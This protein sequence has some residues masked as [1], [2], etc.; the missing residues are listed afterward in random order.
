MKPLE[1][2]SDSKLKYIFYHLDFFIDFNPLVQYISYGSNN[3]NEIT[4]IYIP[5]QD[6]VPNT[7]FRIQ[8]LPV[9]FTCSE[10]DA[11][12]HPEKKA[13]VFHHDILK[14]IFYLLSGYQ[15]YQTKSLDTLGRF[16]Y[17]SSVQYLTKTTTVPLVNYYFEIL[18]EALNVFCELNQL[19]PPK[20]KQHQP[21][22]FLS[23]DV[24]RV[25]KY[26]VRSIG[27]YLLQLLKIKPTT[28]SFPVGI[29]NLI[30]HFCG[31]AFHRPDPFWTF[32]MLIDLERKFNLHSTWYFLEK[33]G[34]K[35]AQYSLDERHIAELI[36]QLEKNDH[37]IGIHGTIESS[38]DINQLKQSLTR[39][40]HLS[41]QE[42]KG[43]RQHF[44][45]YK[46]P[47]TTSIQENA[48]LEY[49]ATLG[50]AE[51]IGYRNSYCHPFKLYDFENDKMRDI[52]QIPLNVMEVSLLGYMKVPISNFWQHIQPL[53]DETIKFKGVFSM[54][55]HNCQLD[56]HLYP[57]MNNI[58]IGIL[59]NI[60]QKELISKT[61]KQII[62][63][64]KPLPTLIL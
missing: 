42:I 26:S 38:V 55:W 15:E 32:P 52:W 47:T 20:R 45:M 60:G 61:G 11:W 22:F 19:E 41:S 34:K 64:Y 7:N 17:Y 37:E 59:K 29:K 24:D 48:G 1:E 23:H 2:L 57:G 40:S 63:S 8:N 62:D 14:S 44:L 6:S 3:S 31:V 35:N 30:E 39:L 58:Y 27:H 16:D 21:T 56:E 46:N 51:H 9:L 36:R 28:E 50:F 4:C 18:I 43:I 10:E 33:L 54:L 13:I 53:V 25:R 5:S 12:Y 49:D